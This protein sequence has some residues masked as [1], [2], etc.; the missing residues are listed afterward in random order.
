MRT[1][2]RCGGGCGDGG[3]GG[4]GG[5]CVFVCVCELVRTSLSAIPLTPHSRSQAFIPL[6]LV[7][8]TLQLVS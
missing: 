7:P 8:L 5:V 3:G 6:T 4:G 1:V 2:E